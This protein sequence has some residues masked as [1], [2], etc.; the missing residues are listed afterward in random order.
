MV[1][2]VGM[3]WISF[4]L[5]IVLVAALRDDNLCRV[6]VL[7]FCSLDKLTLLSRL[8]WFWTTAW[9]QGLVPWN[10]YILFL[11]ATILLFHSPNINH[12]LAS[13]C[14][15]PCHFLYCFDSSLFSWEVMYHCEEK[16][17]IMYWILLRTKHFHLQPV[18]HVQSFQLPHSKLSLAASQQQ[19]WIYRYHNVSLPQNALFHHYVQWIKTVKSGRRKLISPQNRDSREVRH[20]SWRFLFLCIIT[21]KHIVIWEAFT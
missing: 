15:Y 8:I 3:F 1:H 18:L 13:R 14:Q 12:Y 19:C 21:Y 10:K 20:I 11:K 7:A 16:E 9:A 4:W 5:Q 17:G 2:I 6:Y